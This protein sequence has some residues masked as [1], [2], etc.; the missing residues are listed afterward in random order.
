MTHLKC[1]FKWTVAR[2]ISYT[3]LVGERLDLG[4][5]E[6]LMVFTTYSAPPTYMSN[7]SSFKQFMV[8]TKYPIF[9]VYVGF[10][11]NCSLA[12]ETECHRRAL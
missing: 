10:H 11:A 3:V 9:I 2:N 1:V 5:E 6:L 8:E 12:L 4:Q 7:H